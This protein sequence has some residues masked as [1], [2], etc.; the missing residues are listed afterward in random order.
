MVSNASTSFHDRLPSQ[1]VTRGG[2]STH[3]HGMAL[4]SLPEPTSDRLAA[5]VDVS[6]MASSAPVAFNNHPPPRPQYSLRYELSMDTRAQLE[7]LTEKLKKAQSKYRTHAQ[8]MVDLDA[9]MRDIS[10]D[11]LRLTYEDKGLGA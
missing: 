2:E 6:D 9:K 11:M 5:A 4:P 8:A 1:S 10:A 3:N 7:G